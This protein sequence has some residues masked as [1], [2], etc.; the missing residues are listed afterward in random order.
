MYM[1]YRNASDSPPS[2]AETHMQSPST[3]C[4]PFDLR[5]DRDL[6]IAGM[7]IQYRREIYQSPACIYN[8][9]ERSINRRHV[10]T[11]QHPTRTMTGP[12]G[13]RSVVSASWSPRPSSRDP[14]AISERSIKR[15]HVLQSESEFDIILPPAS[16]T[17]HHLKCKVH[18]YNFHHF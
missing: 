9:E 3:P 1:Q 11:Q 15:R 4:H 16:V 7:Y 5:S 14:P 10:Y 12:S 6:S 8:I 2:S 13:C 18:Q 17:I